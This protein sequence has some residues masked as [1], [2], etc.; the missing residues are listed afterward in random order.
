MWKRGK[1]RHGHVTARMA[2]PPRFRGRPPSPPSISHAHFDNQH[3]LRRVKA[4]S[5][6]DDDGVAAKPAPKKR[7]K[8][9]DADENAKP[10]KGKAKKEQD[11]EVI[12]KGWETEQMQSDDLDKWQTLVH[13]GVL[14]PPLYEPLLK[15]VKM[16][17]EG[18]YLRAG[19]RPCSAD[20]S[21]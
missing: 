8:K 14:F 18:E 9:E 12:F 13:A 2:Q 15:G 4:E 21:L 5:D 17:Y 1:G 19:S 6:A 16:K 3:L 7:A 11:E 10:K 20:L